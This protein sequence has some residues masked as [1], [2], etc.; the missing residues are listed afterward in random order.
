MLGAEERGDILQEELLEH[1]IGTSSAPAIGDALAAGASK[2]SAILGLLRYGINAGDRS[3]PVRSALAAF[4]A[5]VAGALL[6]I[7]PWFF[8]SGKVAIVASSGTACIAALIIGGVSWQA[9]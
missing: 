8:L 7:V 3:S 6:P 1:G 9:E 5:S 2:S 4:L